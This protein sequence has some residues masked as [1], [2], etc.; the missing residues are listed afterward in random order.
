MESNTKEKS[1]V[2][3]YLS[4]NKDEAK[5]SV[6]LGTRSLSPASL[7]K[8]IGAAIFDKVI[9]FVLST[10]IAPLISSTSGFD[11]VVIYI[12]EVLAFFYAGY[13]YSARSA[14]PGKLVFG[15]QIVKISGEKLNFWEAGLRDS[16]GKLVSS[17]ILGIG[18]LIAFVRADRCA[19]HDLIFKTQ[20]VKKN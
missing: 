9:L 4:E 16:I 5:Q 10:L 7:I 20:V 11:M 14:T 15:I 19:L 3:E 8:R 2:E 12:N 18:Y 6:Q 13:F 1:I 17:S